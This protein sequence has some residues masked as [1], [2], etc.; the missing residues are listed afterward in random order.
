MFICVRILTCA[1]YQHCTHCRNYLYA[2]NWM[3]DV[4]D[5][6]DTTGVC[7]PHVNITYDKPTGELTVTPGSHAFTVAVANGTWRNIQSRTTMA[8]Y[9]IRTLNIYNTSSA[10]WW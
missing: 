2:T 3:Y 1:H 6:A 5:S 9:G 7:I 8:K 4:R 10:M